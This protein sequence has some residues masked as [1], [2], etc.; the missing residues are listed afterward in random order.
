MFKKIITGIPPSAMAVISGR[1]T[2]C[3]IVFFL[4]NILFQE[5]GLDSR[6]TSL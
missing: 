6:L 3:G 4:N 1:D 2:E 5:N